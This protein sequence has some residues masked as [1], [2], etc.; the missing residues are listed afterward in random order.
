MDKITSDHHDSQSL[1]LVAQHIEQLSQLFPE[2]I[3]EG[4]VDFDALQDLLGNYIDTPEERFQLNWAGKAQARREAQ[5]RSTGTLRPCPE[6]SAKW[7]ITGNLYIEGDN[8]E[9]L[10][11]LQKSYYKK[12]KMIYIDPPYNTGKDFVYKDNYSDNLAN[13]LEISGQDHSLGT[14]TESDG[15]YHSNW[16]NMMYP[17]L[18]L[19]RN[20]LAN[21]GVILVNMDEH[22]IFNLYKIMCEVFGE[23]NDLGTIIW[24]KR[25][26]KGDAKGISYQHEYISVFTRSI[27]DFLSKNEV[28]RPKKN[29]EAILN[30]ADYLFKKKSS[31]YTLDDVNNDFSQWISNQIG[32]SGGER[33]YNKIDENGNVFQS[34][35]MEKP[36]DP[37]YFYDVMHPQTNKI[38]KIPTKG[39]RISYPTMEELLLNNLILFGKD[40]TTQPRRKYLLKDNMYENIPSLL[41]YGGSDVELLKALD[42][43]FDTPKVV[44]VVKEHVG[45]FLKDDEIILD[46]F[47]GS[48]TTAH[49]VMQLNSEDGGNRKFIMVQLPEVTPEDSEAR[50]AGYKTIAEIGKERIRRA[51]K[52]IVEEL[53]AKESK[54]GALFAE[55][56]KILDIGFKV[57]KLDSSNINTWDS[58]PSNLE[59]ALYNSVQNIKSDR[60]EHDLLYEILLKYGIDL[61]H[62]INEH[63]LASKKV[64]EMGAGALIVCMADHIKP[65]TAEAIAQLW[66]EVKPTAIDESAKTAINCRVVFKDNGFDDNNDKTNVLQ[67]LKQHGID[68]IVTI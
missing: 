23:S 36:K 39:W 16:L 38:C 30:K 48:A 41:Y 5:K 47:S 25:N 34:V 4:K 58:S 33:A 59:G 8:L 54:E 18:K 6:E 9:V 53:K 1:D 29:A 3:K 22:E 63:I 26:P 7:D 20:L 31:N 56:Q 12:I 19:A 66:K 43:P 11:L 67:I 68:N 61:V 49:A 62:P 15:R 24:D 13:Y 42:I 55:E 46:F 17:R 32:L 51:G 28:V 52:K 10:K 21:D 45:A 40:E 27:D 57:F 64:Y 14:N 37:I 44:D 60:T 2:V 35:S 50:K 65:E